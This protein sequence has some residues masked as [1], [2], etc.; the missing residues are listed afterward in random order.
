[1]AESDL[2][3]RPS[4]ILLY[5]LAKVKGSQVKKSGEVLPSPFIYVKRRE[6]EV[7]PYLIGFRLSL[8]ATHRPSATHRSTKILI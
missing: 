5:I 6:D 3:Y 7:L 2:F 8:T 1:M 4:G